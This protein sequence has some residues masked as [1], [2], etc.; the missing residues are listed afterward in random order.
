MA[1]Q[2]RG[3]NNTDAEAGPGP[4]GWVAPH[5][6]VVA[7]VEGR[8]Q[9]LGPQDGARQQRQVPRDGRLGHAAPHGAPGAVKDADAGR[10]CG[11]G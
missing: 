5:A 10:R 8:G 2:G 11:L 4:A 1:P 3:V 6:R 9:R 7:A